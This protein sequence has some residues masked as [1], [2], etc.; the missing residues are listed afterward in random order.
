MTEALVTFIIATYRRPEALRCTLRALQMQA[1]RNWAAIVI[2]DHCGPETEAAIRSLGDPRIRYY[3]LPGR[4]G[5]QSGPNS[6]GLHLAGG[7]FV[8]FLNQDDLLLKDHLSRALERLEAC[9]GD[10]YFGRFA[11]ATKLDHAGTGD[12]VPAF[13]QILPAT[14]DLRELLLR[15]HNCFDPSSFWVVRRPFA[16]AVGPWRP[17][18][19]L[20]RTPL[21]DWLLR[22]W[23]LGGAFCFGDTVTGVRMWTHNVPRGG[24]ARAPGYSGATPEN[25][26]MVERLRREEPDETR[27][28]I[29]SQLERAR[30]ARD[31]ARRHSLPHRLSRRY[32]YAYRRAAK[33]ARLRL[34][35]S[36]YRRLGI[37]AVGLLD[38][39][40][41]RPRGMVLEEVTRRRIGEG[42]PAEP[43]IEE[44]LAAP[45]SH[46][47]L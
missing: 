35:T 8:G 22:A 34:C 10:L 47:V 19:R 20:R 2:G 12:P 41:G 1:H 32:R 23:R 24:Q 26:W 44:F 3:N 21:C 39:L 40:S 46:R 27:S 43:T 37:D 4:F 18:I 13:G 5:E 16:R 30:A 7:D 25:E 14:E 6:A 36:L 45:E 38:R 33:E 28:H 15:D 29:L 11:N 31:A 42:L 17:A 9:G